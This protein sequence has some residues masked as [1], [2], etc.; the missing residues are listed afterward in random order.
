MSRGVDLV[1]GVHDRVGIL[2]VHQDVA[3]T[4][5]SLGNSDRAPG[6]DRTRSPVRPVLRA[7]TFIASEYL[8]G[9]VLAASSR[10]VRAFF[11][12]GTIAALR[13]FFEAG[14]SAA[15]GYWLPVEFGTR[16][17]ARPTLGRATL[18]KLSCFFQLCM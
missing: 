3:V 17:S 14:T 10:R 5:R 6:V 7:A 12:A 11:E 8:G 15:S 18:T 13:A 4:G 1:P 2:A 9:D 16:E